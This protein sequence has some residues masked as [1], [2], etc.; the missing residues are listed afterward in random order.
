MGNRYPI[1]T[2]LVSSIWRLPIFG[3]D[4]GHGQAAPKGYQAWAV[5]VVEMIHAGGGLPTLKQSFGA[6]FDSAQVRIVHQF[7]RF[8]SIILSDLSCLQS[9]ILRLLADT[10]EKVPPPRLDVVQFVHVVDESQVLERDNRLRAV[11]GIIFQGPKQ[12]YCSAP[13]T[14]GL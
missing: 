6:S 9:G 11:H 3:D 2:A 8:H 7:A 5:L 4:F 13:L 10:F 1:E 12:V 14:K